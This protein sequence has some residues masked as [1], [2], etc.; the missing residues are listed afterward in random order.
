MSPP[1]VKP[2]MIASWV[3]LALEVIVVVMR[4][5]QKNMGDDA[6]GRGVATGF[7]MLLAPVVLIAGGLLLWS[8]FGGPKAACWVGFCTAGV[9]AP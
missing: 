9:V 3:V 1:T 5:V 8:S 7:A 2:L 4:F 6:A